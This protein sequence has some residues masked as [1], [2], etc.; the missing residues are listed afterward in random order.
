M[1]SDWVLDSACTFHMCPR[2]DWF[3]TYESAEGSVLMGNNV[4]CRLVGIG[5]V[6]IKMHDGV[7]R[8]LAGVRHIPDLKRILLSLSTLDS[9]GYRYIGEGGVLRVSRGALVVMKAKKVVGNPYVL[10][11]L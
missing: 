1:S 6:R 10:Q 11:S 9:N 4:S 2:R 8:T 7:I 3:S 5:T